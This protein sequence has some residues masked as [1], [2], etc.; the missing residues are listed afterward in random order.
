MENASKALIMA[1]EIIVGVMIISIGVYL[2]NLFGSYSQNTSK[3]I[4]QAQIDKFNIQFEKYYGQR[5]GEDGQPEQIKCTI[6]DIVSLANL[7]NKHNEEYG[8]TSENGKSNNTLYI[9]VEIQLDGFK[10]VKN[11]EKKT[12][13]Q[14]VAI[15][16]EN[17]I[18]S[19]N[20]I[21][22]YKCTKCEKNSATKMINYVVFEEI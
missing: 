16:K 6:H 17:D 4:E 19:N 13:D 14:L 8:L 12:N 9:E 22:Y 7:A 18:N 5:M 2:F 21:K 1:A 20:E 3:Q 10:Y 11:L 15:I